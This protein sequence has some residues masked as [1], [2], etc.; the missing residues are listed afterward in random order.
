MTTP[1]FGWKIL[2]IERPSNPRRSRSERSELCERTEET[3]EGASVE[4]NV[5]SN[6]VDVDGDVLS[7]TSVTQGSNGTVVIGVGGI[8]T[9]TPDANFNGAD[10]F[11]Y[12]ITD[13][14]GGQDMATVNVTVLPEND[15]PVALDDDAATNEDTTVSIDVLANDTDIDGDALE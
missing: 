4:I 1:P 3:S 5:L 6:D 13:G 8:L 14:N 9:Y 15:R 11:T 12:S 10:T 7:V 2:E